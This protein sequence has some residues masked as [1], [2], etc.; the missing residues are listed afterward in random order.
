MKMSHM[1]AATFLVIAV[2]AVT[3]TESAVATEG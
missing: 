3:M 1:T 2:S